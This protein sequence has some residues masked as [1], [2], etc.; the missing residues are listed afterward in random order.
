MKYLKVLFIMTDMLVV[1]SACSLVE[2]SEPAAEKQAPAAKNS[3]IEE[4]EAAV[5]EADNGETGEKQS[6]IAN[7]KEWQ[8]GFSDSQNGLF[9]EYVLAG[10]TVGN[11]S[12]LN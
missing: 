3:A 8:L 9:Q 2:E 11:W 7:G 10:E 6:F 12:E 5:E 4:V 1:A